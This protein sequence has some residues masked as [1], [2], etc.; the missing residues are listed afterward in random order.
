[1]Q[2]DA[3]GDNSLEVGLACDWPA[4]R[5]PAA[6]RR[7]VRLVVSEAHACA[8]LPGRMATTR[9]FWAERIDPEIYHQLMDAG[10]RRSGRVVYQPV[11]SGC[12]ECQPIRVPVDGFVPSKSQRRVW[13]RN[14]DLQVRVARPEPTPEKFALYQRYQTHWHDG[15]MAGGWEEFVGFLY[16]SP[17]PTLEMEYRQADGRLLA[18]GICDVGEASLSSVYFYFDPADARRGLGTF[19]VLREIDLAQRQDMAHYY[20]GFWVR[21][22]GAM[23]YKSAFRPHEVL[24]PTGR[25]QRVG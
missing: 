19:G 17:V 13:R 4:W 2:D 9:A 3:A 16:E 22:C 10:F 20:L 7:R 1:M 12:R 5:V 24:R 6:V 14:A 8:Y 21:Q 23:Q 11:C 18:V 15:S 25:W